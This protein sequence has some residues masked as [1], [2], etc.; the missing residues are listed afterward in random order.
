MELLLEYGANPAA[1]NQ[2]GQ[3]PLQ[4]LPADAVRSTK[5]YFKKS[6]ED[7]MAKIRA[8]AA[9]SLTASASSSNNEL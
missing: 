4:L 2:H 7:A 9:A 1:V 8:G 6:F 5:L 3:Y